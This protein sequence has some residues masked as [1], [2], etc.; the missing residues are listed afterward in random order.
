MIGYAFLKPL[1]SWE[2]LPYLYYLRFK[3]FKEQLVRLQKCYSYYPTEFLYTILL[4][5][6]I[7]QKHTSKDWESCLQSF[8]ERYLTEKPISQTPA[9]DSPPCNTC[10][11]THGFANSDMMVSV[12]IVVCDSDQTH[13]LTFSSQIRFYLPVYLRP[14]FYF[15][16]STHPW[17][18]CS[19]LS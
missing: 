5:S 3:L 18:Q 7:E 11:F 17:H 9:L 14:T 10:V 15:P 2:H 8:L 12:P 13:E 16:T 1:S 6:F 19:K 4:F